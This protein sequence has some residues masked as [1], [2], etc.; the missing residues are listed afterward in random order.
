MLCTYLLFFC[1]CVR[2]VTTED[3]YKINNKNEEEKISVD[4][5][6]EEN[7]DLADSFF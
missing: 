4:S 5:E 6:L 2:T 3:K 1:V 7:D